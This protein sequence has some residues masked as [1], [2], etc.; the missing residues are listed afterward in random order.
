[1]GGEGSM[2]AANQSLKSNRNMLAKR[3]EKSFS[4]VTNST[5]K[6]EYN[7]PEISEA[8]IL[9]LRQK[10]QREHKQRRIKQ[11]ILLA[12]VIFVMF[13]TLIYFA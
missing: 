8:S 7:L 4:F 9:L 12:L 5:E 3:K 13:G 11:I 2:M 10:L 1:M 6:T